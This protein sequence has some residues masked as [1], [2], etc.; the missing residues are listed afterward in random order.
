MSWKNHIQVDGMLLQTDKKFSGLKEKQKM[1]IAEWFYEGFRQCYL[2]SGRF[3]NQQGDEKILL[4]AYQFYACVLT[5]E[6]RMFLDNLK[7]EKEVSFYGTS[8]SSSSQSIR[9]RD[10][11]P[12]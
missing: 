7:G 6:Q 10:L 4:Y 8:Y 5:Q 9:F 2:N 12:S 3:P 11:M 1:K